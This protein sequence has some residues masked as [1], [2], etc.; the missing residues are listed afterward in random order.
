MLLAIRLDCRS[1]LEETVLVKLGE[2]VLC[3]L[4]LLVGWCPAKDIKANVEPFVNLGVELVVLVAELL[5]CALF[6]YGLC[7][8]CG[9]VFV[10]TTD[11]Q[12]RKTA[13]FAISVIVSKLCHVQ[14]FL[15]NVSIPRENIC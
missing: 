3:N 15:K 4:G 7:L 9:T 5:G 1:L 10:S 6:F 12:G 14:Y 11:E 13:S 8:G 2:D